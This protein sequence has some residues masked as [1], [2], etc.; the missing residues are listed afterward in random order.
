M[1]SGACFGDVRSVG[2]RNSSVAHEHPLR[3]IQLQSNDPTCMIEVDQHLLLLAHARCYE[4][5]VV[6]EAK[7]MRLPAIDLPI[8][9]RA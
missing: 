9:V 5:D 4:H 6:S 2:I 1:F 3:Q 7:M 8:L